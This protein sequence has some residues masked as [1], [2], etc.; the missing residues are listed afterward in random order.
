MTKQE[1]IKFL[2]E[3]VNV[4]TWSYHDMSRLSTDIVVHKLLIKP[5]CKL[6]QQKLRRMGLDMLL[7]IKKEVKK[8]FDASFLE[9]ANYSQ[10]VENIVPVLKKYEKVR[11]C[12]DYRDLNRASPKDNF[13]LPYI[14]MLVEKLCDTF[15]SFSWI[16]SQGSTK[17]RWNQRT[18][19]RPHS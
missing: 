15:Y 17:S 16:D 7:K 11:M 10:W 6:I 9:M 1:L 13:S 12:I 4:F 18:W 3:Y 19:K 2:Q 5:G 8:Q 14:D